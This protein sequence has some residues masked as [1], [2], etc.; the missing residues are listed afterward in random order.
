MNIVVGEEV[1]EKKLTLSLKEVPWDEAMNT[2]LEGNNLRKLKHGENTILVTTSENFKKI[3]DDENKAKLDTIKLEQE[4]LKAEEQRQKVGKVLWIN[5]QFQIKNVDV[6]LVEDLILST[7]EKEK[8]IASERGINRAGQSETTITI[9]TR[10]QGG[11][12]S[13]ISIPHTNTLIARGTERDLDYIEDLIKSIDQ[14][15]SQVM[16]EARIIEAD[17]NYTRD[18]GLRWGGGA[19]L[20]NTLC[21]FAGTVRGGEAG[22]QGSNY[23]VNLPLATTSQAFG[24]LG[25]AFASTN[26]NI[27]V[28]IQAMEQQ[29][30]GKT[31]SSP[32]ILTLDKKKASIEHT[33][34]I[35]ITIKDALGLVTTEWKNAG[36]RL[37]VTPYIIARKKFR[38]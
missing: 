37:F 29:G 31:I 2:I 33:Q 15:V 1:K 32:K 5:R 34:E 22:V 3:L 20:G 19:A 30:R 4:E 25:F 38:I 9:A 14:P 35:P 7:I 28:R 24:G 27:D 10:R 13:I 36:L 12:V 6:K 8:K 16:I 18:I 17:A 21:P 11:D 26:L 23:A